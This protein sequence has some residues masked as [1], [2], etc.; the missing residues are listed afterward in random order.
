MKFK[1]KT[2]GEVEIRQIAKIIK[3]KLEE[4]PEQRFVLAVGSDSQNTFET[5]M[6]QVIVLPQVGT[7]GIF[8]YNSARLKQIKTLREKLLK[9][10]EYSLEVANELLCELE[11]LFDLENFDYTAYPV[12]LQFH[13]D[14]GYSGKSGLI[15]RDLLGY[16][17]GMLQ[18]SF[19]IF[20]KPNAFAASCIADKISKPSFIAS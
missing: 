2:Y 13:C 11:R 8:F 7:G 16:V 15:V 18:E 6:V 9:E 19:E 5:R 10:T 12:E 14:I 17:K 4:N 20:I 3:K 1:S